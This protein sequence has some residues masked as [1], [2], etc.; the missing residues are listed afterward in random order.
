MPNIDQLTSLAELLRAKE[1]LLS[2]QGVDTGNLRSRIMTAIY[3]NGTA[4]QQFAGFFEQ[5]TLLKNE[6]DAL[7]GLP[8]IPAYTVTNGTTLRTLNANSYTNDNL[9]DILA[10]LISDLRNGVPIPAYTI[11]NGT[12]L[13][14]LNANSYTTDNLAD[15]IA[16]IIDDLGTGSTISGYTVTNDVTLRT[17][18]ANSYTT[19]NLADVIATLIRDLGGV[20]VTA[21][22]VPTGLTA[23]ME[24]DTEIILDDFVSTDA[25]GVTGYEY[26]IDGGSAVDMGL[27][28]PFTV[29]GLTASTEYGF[30]VRAYDA[31]G[32]ASAWSSVVSETTDA[33]TFSGL[34]D[35]VTSTLHGVYSTS[36]LLGG[37]SGAAIR[38]KDASNVEEDIGFDVGG[39]LNTGALSGDAPY[40]VVK[41][42]DQSG[43]G[44]DWTGGLLDTEPT[45]D[46][47]DKSIRFENQLFD[48]GNLSALTEAEIFVKRKIDADPTIAGEGSMYLMGTNSDKTH[49]PYTNGQIYD[50]FGTDTRKDTGVNPTDSM[51]AYHVYNAYSKTDDWACY[52]NDGT[53][54]IYSTATNTVSFP[55]NTTFGRWSGGY[56][57]LGNVKAVVLFSEK[58]TSGDR[59]LVSG[60]L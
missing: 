60:G 10:T 15:L 18:D 24:S 34:L 44:R 36:K 50:S 57:M 23:T 55:S 14:T 42:Y 39:E 25:V 40:K 45:L 46:V 7:A 11:T 37:Y 30:E 35:D 31:A 28:K 13:R 8:A 52:L 22:T 17:L 26:R 5:L 29:S 3:L 56:Y 4:L 53:T 38:V 33:S 1:A 19:D 32:N 27:T 59:I 47:A 2:A 9:A 58:V 6:L 16:T 51:T 54:P 41:F 20:D 43:N 48:S 12:V 49:I 21:P